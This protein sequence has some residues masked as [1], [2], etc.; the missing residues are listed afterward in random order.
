MSAR[1][2]VL[3][4]CTGN[5]AR[6]QMAEGLLRHLAGD[7]F[8]VYSAGTLPSGMSEHTIEAMREIG[9]DVSGQR[10]KSVEEFDGQSFEYVI[11]V[12]DSARQVCP[13]FPGDGE[14]LHWDVEDPSDMEARGVALSKAFRM[15][16]D[17]LRKRIELFAEEH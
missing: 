2:R 9:I 1:R 5:R 13:I 14:R 12:C 6:S 7:S 3:F 11:T 8:E 15:A 10:S 16:R 4:V 17:D